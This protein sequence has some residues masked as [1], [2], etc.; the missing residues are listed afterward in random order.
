MTLILKIDRIKYVLVDERGGARARVRAAL[1]S[2]VSGRRRGRRR[3]A[4]TDSTLYAR[5][6][7]GTSCAMRSRLG[8]TTGRRLQSTH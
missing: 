7:G 3:D 4:P 1:L 5:A 2:P 6:R 8:T